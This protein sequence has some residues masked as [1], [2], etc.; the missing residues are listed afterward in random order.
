[1]NNKKIILKNVEKLFRLSRHTVLIFRILQ[2]NRNAKLSY[3]HRIKRSLGI[4]NERNFKTNLQQKVKNDASWLDLGF[5]E[6]YMIGS[7]LSKVT[8]PKTFPQITNTYLRLLTQLPKFISS[9]NFAGTFTS[10]RSKYLI[11]STFLKP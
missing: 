10:V 5:N 2:R 4:E 1:M 11:I 9:A 3:L 7:Q 6:G 8:N